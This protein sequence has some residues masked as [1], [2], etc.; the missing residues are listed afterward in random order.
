MRVFQPA[1]YGRDHGRTDN[2]ME[3]IPGWVGAPGALV[4]GLSSPKALMA[5]IESGRIPP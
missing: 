2:V 5:A 4:T 1:D 3:G